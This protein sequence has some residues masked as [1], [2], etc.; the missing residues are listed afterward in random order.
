MAG[1]TLGIIGLGAIGFEVAKRANAFDMQLAAYDPYLAP[2]RAEVLKQM[3]ARIEKD[4]VALAASCDILTVHVPAMAGTDGLISKKLLE[5]VKPGTVIINT[6]RGSIIDEEAL[7]EAMETKGLRAGLDVYQGE[8][9]ASDK[10]FDSALAKH[11][12]VYGTH[13]IGAST[14]QSQTAIAD[15]VIESLTAFQ[16]G[17]PLNCVNLGSVVGAEQTVTVRHHNR[18]G[19]LAAVLVTLREAGL[20]VEQMENFVLSGRA[21]ATALIHVVGEMS[22]ETIDKLESVENVIAVSVSA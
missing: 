13:H 16:N 8:P 2:D 22:D 11:P 15:A 18:V 21:A 7:L 5:A 17:A 4:T 20:N 19:V 1:R 12:S 3:G 9:G 10:T 14:E 6:S